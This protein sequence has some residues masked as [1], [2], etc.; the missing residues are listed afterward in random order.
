MTTTPR[1]P[2]LGLE[3]DRVLWPDGQLEPGVVW[4][5]P[6]QGTVA[7]VVRSGLGPAGTRPEDV[8]GT[9]V[10]LGDSTVAPGFVDVHVHGGNGYEV[11]GASPTAVAGAVA[12]L[13]EFHARHGTT[14]LVATTMADSPARLAATVSGVALSARLAPGG[15]ARVLGCHLE[16]PFIS[17]HRAGAQD[18]AAIRPPDRAELSRLLE[19]GE[20]SVRIVTL[21][22]ELEGARALV[23][24]CVGAG[25][26]VSLGHSDADVDTARAAFDAGATHV[27]HLFDAMAP[28]HHRRPGLAAAALLEDRATLELICD[29]QHVHPAAIALTAR[30]APGRV[31]LVTDATAATG[32]APGAYRLGGVE[33]HLEDAR[34]VLASDSST[35]AG[36][37]L[38]ME[39]A[40]RHA[41][42]DAGM[43][44]GDALRAASAVPALLAASPEGHR[45]GPPTGVLETGARADLVVLD[46]ELEVAATVVG[47]AVVFDRDGRLA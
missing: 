4:V 24:D 33:V 8:A 19:L 32:M 5:D 37:V 44:L 3:S 7:D 10:R 22:P 14:S 45:T 26:T 41:V 38:T 31:V 34:V 16:G 2:L 28:F 29:L 17:P 18:P 36:S 30:T 12:A 43:P 46:P 42:G 15:G 40:V 21:A 11:N 47:G 20:G 9:L 39:R 1:A 13:A 23:A 35:L 6:G 25:V 27:T